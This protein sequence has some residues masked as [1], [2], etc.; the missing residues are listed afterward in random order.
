MDL[1]LIVCTYN[2]CQ[3][4]TETL[5][6][7][8]AQVVPDSVEWEIVVVDNNSTDSTRTV[9]EESSKKWPGRFRY[10][11]EGRQGLSAAR[12]SGIRNSRGMVLAFTDDDVI[13]DPHWLW[14]LTL[15]LT[16]EEW[17]GSGGR[18]VPVWAKPLPNWM[19]INDPYTMGPFVLFDAGSEPRVLDRPPYGANMAFRRNIFEKYGVF[20]TDLGRSGGNLNSREDIEFGERLL[21]AGERLRYEPSAVVFHP[22]SENRMTERFVLRWWFWFGYGEV[23]QIG[24]PSDTR[25]VLSGIPLYLFRRIVR[26]V[27]QWIVTFNPPH[28]FACMRNV[29]YLSGTILACHRIRRFN[30]ARTPSEVE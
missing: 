25:W 28:K 27:L 29:W 9:V 17:A 30:E 15:H 19:S 1:S 23:V 10:I 21:S 7:I 11:F 14:N 5:E 22:A 18:I 26:W 8:A 16:S 3:S 6:S 13:T 20:R 24:Q 2:R 12:N 4:L